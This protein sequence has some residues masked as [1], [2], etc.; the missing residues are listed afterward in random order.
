MAIQKPAKIE[1]LDC[2]M[3]FEEITWEDTSPNDTVYYQTT[4]GKHYAHG[5]FT[6]VDPI[7]HRLR[8]KQNVEVNLHKI[9]LL[10]LHI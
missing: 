9:R 10:K 1:W 4:S 5:P 8:N 2:L 7:K 6:V 3:S